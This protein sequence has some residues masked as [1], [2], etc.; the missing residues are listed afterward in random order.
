MLASPFV[1]RFPHRQLYGEELQVDATPVEVE[2]VEL[3]EDE[4]DGDEE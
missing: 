2:D 4:E 3:T 1:L